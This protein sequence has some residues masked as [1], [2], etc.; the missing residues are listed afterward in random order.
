MVATL[1]SER[2]RVDHTAL[3]SVDALL[4]ELRAGRPVVL[5]DDERRENEGDLVLPAELATPEWINFMVKEA[6]GLVCVALTPERGRVLDLAAMVQRNTDA[7]ATAFTVSVDH[8]DTSTGISAFDRSRT[9]IALADPD[10]RPDD[11]RRPGHVFPLVA[12]PDGVLGRRGHTEA[13]VDLASLAG[14]APV[15]VICEIM[16]DDGH[17]ARLDDLRSFAARHGLRVG[18]VESLI[19]HRLALGGHAAQRRRDASRRVVSRPVAGDER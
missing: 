3:A 6:R 16:R 19:E 13:A 8:V 7:H 10:A 15:G 1:E 14:F 18:T 11:F 17:M 2:G 4:D 12:H 5:V 9:S